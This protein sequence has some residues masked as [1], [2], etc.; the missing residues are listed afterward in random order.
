ML[1]ATKQTNKE[2]IL[3]SVALD[4]MLSCVSS[5]KKKRFGGI[6]NLV[7]PLRDIRSIR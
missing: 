2:F 7:L 3:A 4:A 6:G 1:T 5:F